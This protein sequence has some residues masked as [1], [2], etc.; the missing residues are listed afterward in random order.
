[1]KF[2]SQKAMRAGEWKYLSI[3]GDEFLFNLALDERERANFA[4][5]EP[6]RIAAL[7]ARYAEWRRCCPN[8]PKRRSPCRRR[9][10]IS[11]NPARMN[12]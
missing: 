2:R 11:R 12:L 4:A 8:F 10:G 7:R 3:E 6:K 1:M 9:K 5:R